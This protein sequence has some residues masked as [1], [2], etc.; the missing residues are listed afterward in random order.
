[1]P[2]TNDEA[3]LTD[4]ELFELMAPVD[5]SHLPTAEERRA[6]LAKLQPEIQAAV[7][8]ETAMRPFHVRFPMPGQGK[9]T[10]TGSS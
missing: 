7:A 10:K 8:R 3:E 9:D 5:D 6:I 4:D 2:D 1:M